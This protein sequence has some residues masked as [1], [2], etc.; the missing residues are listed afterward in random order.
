MKFNS[1]EQI[2]PCIED[3][4][5]LL[6]PFSLRKWMKLGFIAM[7]GGNGG[8]GGGGGNNLNVTLPSGGGDESGVNETVNSVTGSA[9]E[10]A[11]DKAAAWGPVIGGIVFLLLMLIVVMSYIKSV[12]TFMFIECIDTR[13]VQIGKYWRKNQG[14][15]TSFFLFKL[16]MTVIVLA[17]I[18]L[19]TSPLWIQLA[20]Q[21]WTEFSVNFGI[22]MIAW[23]I[24]AVFF[25]VILLI[26]FAIFMMLVYNF[27]LL[28]M[29][30]HKLP[31]TPSLKA[32]F[33]KMGQK[34]VEVLVFVLASMVIGIVLTIVAVLMVL[35]L[36]I[37]FLLVGVPLGIGAY[38]L[39]LAVA[40]SIPFIVVLVLFGLAFFIFFLWVF[41]ICYLPFS[42]YSWYFSIRNYRL[43][44]K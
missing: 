12:F 30:Y 40:W 34:K 35:I 19:C 44:M 9:V 16:L 4:K 5:K 18:A 11:K 13:K 2:A 7:L 3:P 10:T 22:G 33:K 43:L 27:T 25:L 17:I 37:P 39:G 20:V 21:G 8:G 26:P 31:I 41:S 28:H 36:A 15:G 24:L 6:M 29:Y 23:I 42:T 1:F 14:L 32:T 38:F